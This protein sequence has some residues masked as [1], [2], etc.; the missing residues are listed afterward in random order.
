MTRIILHTAWADNAGQR[1]E[2][3]ETVA[4]GPA[5]DEIAP[6]QAQALLDA[7]SAVEAPAPRRRAKDQGEVGADE[8][9]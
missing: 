4:I 9:E 8:A 1:R 3:G 6:E 5:P 2:A 7:C